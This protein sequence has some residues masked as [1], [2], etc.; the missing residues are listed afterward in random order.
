MCRYRRNPRPQ[1]QLQH[2]H[3]NP[4]H[5]LLNLF[6]GLI[7]FVPELIFRRARFLWKFGH[8]F[9]YL[10]FLLI[11]TIYRLALHIL[12]ILASLSIILATWFVNYIITV[13]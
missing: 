6:I 2:I 9:F 7:K 1:Q 3:A 12:L 11:Y 4:D 5:D 8:R 13:N 10:L